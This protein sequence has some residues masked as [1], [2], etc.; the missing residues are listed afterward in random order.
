MYV[1]KVAVFKKRNY[2]LINE[3]ILFI[4]S[5]IP[6]SVCEQWAHT[7]RRMGV[8]ELSGPCAIIVMFSFVHAE[9]LIR[10]GL[11]IISLLQNIST[12]PESVSVMHNLLNYD[13]SF[14][15]LQFIEF[16]TLL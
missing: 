3:I 8:R 9:L 13:Q 2:Q 16:N 7:C 4:L 12:T 5:L 11:D 15:C 6:K 10:H 1:C 14:E